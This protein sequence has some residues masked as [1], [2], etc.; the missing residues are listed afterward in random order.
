MSGFVPDGSDG[1]AQ[2]ESYNWVVETKIQGM[3]NHDYEQAKKQVAERLS[4]IFADHWKKGLVRSGVTLRVSTEALEALAGQFIASMIAKV[5]Q[6]SRDPKALEQVIVCTHQFLAFLDREIEGVARKVAYEIQEMNKSR[7]LAQAAKLLW[8]EK[9]AGLL[10][11]LD[12]QRYEFISSYGPSEIAATTE[13][14]QAKADEP[15]QSCQ[16]PQNCDSCGHWDKLSEG[17]AN[18]A[19]LCRRFALAPSFDGWPITGAEDH[20]EEWSALE[21]QELPEAPAVA[22]APDVREALHTWDSCE[23]YR[24]VAWP[25]RTVSSAFVDSPVRRAV[26]FDLVGV[27]GV[28]EPP[29]PETVKK[30]SGRQ[31]G[32]RQAVS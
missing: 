6:I 22:P 1:P 13:V 28:A 26:K 11:R 2:A 30:P 23:A 29:A 14:A 7:G 17:R 32:R 24:N 5:S 9:R 16:S 18:H 20:C 4:E 27:L 3:L 19:G 15:E 10:D 12:R 8:T 21:D 31:W 25:S